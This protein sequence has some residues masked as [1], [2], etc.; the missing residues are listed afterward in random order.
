MTRIVLHQ[1]V[2]H[3]QAKWSSYCDDTVCINW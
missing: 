3:L 1:E 2:A